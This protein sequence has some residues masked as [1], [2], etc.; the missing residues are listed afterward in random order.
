MTEEKQATVTRPIAEIISDLSKEIAERHLK[1]KVLKGRKIHFISWHHAIKYL[2]LFAPGW[3]GEVRQVAEIGGRCVIVYRISIPC[4]EGTVWREATGQESDWDEEEETKYGD[5]SSNAEA[6]A[7]K[8]AAAKF[9]LGLYLYQGAPTGSGGGTGTKPNQQQN[10]QQRPAAA[11]AQSAGQQRAQRTAEDLALDAQAPLPATNGGWQIGE[12]TRSKLVDLRS[13][14]DEFDIGVAWK[15]EKMRQVA[16]VDRNQDLTPAG[17]AKLI[18]C[19]SGR[20]NQEMARQH[21]HAA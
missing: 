19:F 10:A 12:E 6:M 18:R 13:K 3:D 9:G 5:P 14:L 7:F 17:A 11:P 4:A 15:I 1:V 16:G 2:D 8:R 21:S 20:I